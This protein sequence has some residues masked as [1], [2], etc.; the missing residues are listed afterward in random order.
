MSEIREFN[1]ELC[2]KAGKLFIGYWHL[3][4]GIF[5]VFIIPSLFLYLY[6]WRNLV[7]KGALI[8]KYSF[9]TFVFMENTL[10]LFLF[11]YFL[12][13]LIANVKMIH[14]ADPGKSKGVFAAYEQAIN[15]FHQYLWIKVLYIFK[16]LCWMM[17]LIVPGVVF[18]IHYNFSGMACLIDNKRGAEALIMS[19]KIIKPNLSKYLKCVILSLV[20]LLA[21]CVIFLFNMHYLIIF[22]SIKDKLFMA[23]MFEYIEFSFVALTGSYFLT[24]Y[25]YLYGHLKNEVNVN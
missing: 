3:F 18:G 13:Y 8:E 25:Y 17:L 20:I 6:F 9:E 4:L 22:F 19:R 24:Y 2:N 1:Q 16:V 5:A 11:L 23:R 21:F 15:I 12:L 10:Y 14:A 7:L